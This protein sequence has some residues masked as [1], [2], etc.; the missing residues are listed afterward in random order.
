[1]VLLSACVSTIVPR[2]PRTID[3]VHG[4]RIQV[5]GPSF[6][7]PA[8]PGASGDAYLKAVAAELTSAGFT[9]VAA[10]QPGDLRLILDRFERYQVTATVQR[11]D[12]VVDSFAVTSQQAG[13]ISGFWG[14]SAAANAV[15]YARTLID[16]LLASPR[17]AARGGEKEHAAPSGSAS[18][19]P[20]SRRES[21]LDEY[22]AFAEFQATDEDPEGGARSM[23]K[24]AD[25]YSTLAFEGSK[26]NDEDQIILDDAHERILAKSRKTYARA[27]DIYAAHL[28]TAWGPYRLAGCYLLGHGR[29]EDKSRMMQLYEQAAGNGESRAMYELG[30]QYHN[31]FDGL[32]KDPAK[33]A[34]WFLKAA[35]KGHAGAMS[36]LAGMYETGEGVAK[37]P[38]LAAKWRQRAATVQSKP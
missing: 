1:L 26:V 15:C 12:A 19:A 35:E 4:Q 7:D 22:A 17:V 28:S 31:G 20:K 14:V 23:E 33:A 3:W 38:D 18:G 36:Y 37:D 5:S 16:T 30:R 25:G 11:G 6:V 9:V 8:G 10:A 29:P 21:E 27:C 13:C 34:E 2:P 32:E 24:V